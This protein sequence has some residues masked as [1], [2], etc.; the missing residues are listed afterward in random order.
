MVNVYIV[1]VIVMGGCVGMICSSDDCFNLDLSVF[2][3]MGGDG[4]FGINFE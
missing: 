1:E 4:G 3:E 2:V